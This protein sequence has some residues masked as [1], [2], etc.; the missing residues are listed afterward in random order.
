MFVKR[1]IASSVKHVFATS[2]SNI[3]QE[4]LEELVSVSAEDST[5]SQLLPVGLAAEDEADLVAHFYARR[6]KKFN[7][8]REYGLLFMGM[9]ETSLYLNSV[10]FALRTAYHYCS[11]WEENG[12]DVGKEISR[13]IQHS[14]ESNSAKGD[15]LTRFM[16]MIASG[17]QHV[18]K[19]STRFTNGVDIAFT[20]GFGVSRT[21]LL[22]VGVEANSIPYDSSVEGD[23]TPS[24]YHTPLVE[25]AWLLQKLLFPNEAELQTL[26]G[27]YSRVVKSLPFNTRIEDIVRKAV[28]E[29]PL[30]QAG[31]T[32]TLPPLTVPEAKHEFFSKYNSAVL[33]RDPEPLYVRRKKGNSDLPD[34]S[35]NF[36]MVR[37]ALQ[38]Q[39][40]FTFELNL[41]Q[42]FV[43]YICQSKD[44]VI[45]AALN[46]WASMWASCLIR[47]P[48]TRGSGLRP[49]KIPRYVL[50]PSL[51]GKLIERRKELGLYTEEGR[52]NQ[53]GLYI[54]SVGGLCHLPAQA[55]ADDTNAKEYEAALEEALKVSYS[56]G[57]PLN[58]ATEGSGGP[59]F[60][61]LDATYA[62]KVVEAK[63]NIVSFKGSLQAYSWDLN[64]I[65]TVG[66]THPDRFV[67][68][69]LTGGT[70]PDELAFANIMRSTF[71]EG[72]VNM[73]PGAIA[74][75]GKDR[76]KAGVDHFH[77]STT[78]LSS[79]SVFNNVMRAYNFFLASKAVPSLED[80]VAA[81]KRALN[82]QS[83]EDEAVA[84]FELNRYTGHS[85]YQGLNKNLTFTPIVNMGKPSPGRTALSWLNSAIQDAGAR[86]GASNLLRYCVNN[87]LHEDE[88]PRFFRGE[89]SRVSEFKNVFQYF[90]GQVFLQMLK[91]LAAIPHK[92]L[93]RANKD[94]DFADPDHHINYNALHSEV[95]PFAKMF[96]KYVTDLHDKI[97]EKADEIADNNRNPKVSEDQLNIAGALTSDEPGKG[98]QMFP[99]QAETLTILKN[100]PRFAILQIAP[101]GGKTFLGLADIAMLYADGL[102]KRPVIVC[103]NGLVGNWCEDIRKFVGTNWNVIP[104]T[105]HTYNMWGDKRLT[106]LIL[107]APANTIL[108]VG[109]S[110]LGN[111]EKTQLVIGNAVESV[112]DSLEFI[113][114]FKPDYVYVDESHRLR[115]VK[116][117]IHGLV[118]SL[119]QTSSVKYGRLA[120]GTFIQN[121]LSDAVGQ[122]ALYSAQVF[123]TKDEF[124][125]AHKTSF[126]SLDGEAVSD[127]APEAPAKVFEQLS[128][129]CTVISK[130]RKE[131]AFM[132]PLP[133]E[134]FIP[135]QFEDV[136]PE[137]GQKHR[138]MYEAVLKKTLEALRSDKAIQKLLKGE[139]ADEDDEDDDAESPK[140]DSH[141]ITTASGIKIDVADNE[142]DSENLD[143]LEAKLNPYLQ[144]LERLLTDPMGDEEL[145]E[146]AKSFFG[147]VS[148]GS[149]VT[150]KV[151]KTIDI[152]KKHFVRTPWTSGMKVDSSQLVFEGEDS[153][154]FRPSEELNTTKGFVSLKKPSQDSDNWKPQQQGKVIVFCRFTRSVDAI[155]RALPGDLKKKAVVFHGEV[156]G[157]KW[158][159]LDKFKNDPDVQILIANEMA[160]SEGHNLQVASRCIRVESPWAPG[161]LDQSA[162]RIFRPSVGS[163]A[164]QTIYLDWIVCDNT[165]EVAKMGRLIS[166]MLRKAQFDELDNPK[167]FKNLNPRNLPIIKMSLDNI[168][169]LNKLAD[170][171]S[172]A[173]VFDPDDPGNANGIHPDSYI[174]QYGYLVGEYAE[175]FREM[176]KTKRS[177]MVPVAKTPMHEDAKT[178]DFTP[179]VPNMKVLDNQDEGLVP[180]RAALE[181]E[182]SEVAKAFA[183]NPK[184]LIGRIVRTEF[185]LGTIARVS[186]SRVGS[187]EDGEPDRKVSKV[188]VDLMQGGRIEGLSAS[189]VFLATKVAENNKNKDVAKAPKITDEDKKRTEGRRKKLEEAVTKA[190]SGRKKLVEAIK[191]T[192]RVARPVVEE[193]EEVLKAQRVSLY[194]VIY[195]EFLA[196][197]CV[198]EEEGTSL[199]K[200]GFV[201]FGN[202]AWIPVKNY[203]SFTKVLDFLESKFTLAPKTIKYL[204]GLHDSFQSGRGRKFAVE[205]ASPSDFPKFYNMR[206]RMTVVTNRRKPELKLYPVI[207]D[208]SLLLVVDIA[209]NPVI[210]KWIGRNIPG[211][212][213]AIK[214][215]EADGLEIKF[216]DTKNEMVA[217]IRTV[218]QAGIEVINIEELKEEVRALSLKRRKE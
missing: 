65:I 81:A 21:N 112:S 105:T 107:K 195:N 199:K 32:V 56:V 13:L 118:K 161:E 179:W 37:Q 94:T 92:V 49:N 122:T 176:K 100:H 150:A 61:L 152:I 170:L 15:E 171:R 91:A 29:G 198:P 39:L 108:I 8:Q 127:Y 177:Y 125:A 218:R 28:V 58:T 194:P 64:S 115:N 95:I 129:Y 205:L 124:D 3:P 192:R 71:A 153:Y 109:N 145:E 172:F 20:S 216:V 47:A 44:R 174:G 97:L 111:R 41:P 83:L 204:D 43:Q 5:L 85:I 102:V 68:T 45:L 135:V 76:A 113:K 183:E 214:F 96:S 116:S 57:A 16:R 138:M 141:S 19:D 149:F 160:I 24:R 86:N 72:C 162:S 133:I 146:V 209:T 126:V 128:Q 25:A 77:L 180:L 114:K 50:M 217:T 156:D 210:R 213:P 40:G 185:G 63:K 123:R 197:E 101:G 88:H 59:L 211:T 166:K 117:G 203:Q 35:L 9:A 202:Y 6:T 67:A 212:A 189:K 78:D 131:W 48:G 163:N 10:F 7:I 26:K 151:A 215:Q 148:R 167:Y 1:K 11:D 187:D 52:S 75:S 69:K 18:I 184:S 38:P 165:L 4:V 190:T 173:G 70:T 136:D 121:V 30:K 62:D 206:H 182:D 55:E 60:E 2:P 51:S 175:E 17:G 159:N 74:Q 119:M 154:I 89:S 157:N 84:A 188:W 106:D 104:I 80:L 23:R 191:Q 36:N 33:V 164:R 14:I 12:S 66:I 42:H 186:S 134:R 53:D 143:A 207:L 54:S 82:I 99:H 73:F 201:P 31:V 103:P 181:A 139:A 79:I 168:R 178:L 142:D 155:Y 22:N 27:S 90:G 200:Y 34:E 169:G 158:D 208:G 132:L 196:L 137:M 120:T 193:E 98:T 110:F 87:N 147:D 93:A 140:E 46:S 144:R 130:K